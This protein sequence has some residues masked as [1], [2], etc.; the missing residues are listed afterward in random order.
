M[1]PACT[2]GP[3]CPREGQVGRKGTVWSPAGLPHHPHSLADDPCRRHPTPSPPTL[4]QTAEEANSHRTGTADRNAGI[5]NVAYHNFTST[6]GAGVLA[7]PAVMAALGW[8]AGAVTLFLSW[9]ISWMTYVF[10]VRVS[11]VE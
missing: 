7:L 9:F 4:T 3:T 2:C 6:V 8:G 5:S 10:L 11:C 1:Q